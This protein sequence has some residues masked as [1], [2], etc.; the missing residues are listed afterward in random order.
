MVRSSVAA[1]VLGVIL[2]ATPAMASE[3]AGTL[4]AGTGLGS[5]VT[6]ALSSTV[7]GTV[8]GGASGAGGTTGGG[9][10]GGGG[11]LSGPLSVGYVN[12]SGG[13]NGSGGSSVPAVGS[14]GNTT[15]VAPAVLGVSTSNPTGGLTNGSGSSDDTDV[16]LGN[17]GVSGVQDVT[18]TVQGNGSLVAAVAASD[19]TDTTVWWLWAALLVL[20]VAAAGY[21][22]WRYDQ[23]TI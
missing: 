14:T 9:G 1:L 8:T 17:V 6:G 5:Q 4:T 22:Y 19:T 12:S 3:V 21:V 20:V 16:A 7:L 18:P 15:T 11:V 10:S 13:S 23:K 2:C